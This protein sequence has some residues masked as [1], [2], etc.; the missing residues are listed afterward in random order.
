MNKYTALLFCAL[1][2]LS[3]CRYG[4]GKHV[5]GNGHKS[6]ETRNISGFTGVETHGDI[7]IIATVG[8]YSVKVEAEQNLLSY[9]E[10]VVEDGRL[11]VRI[12]DGIALYDFD[13]ATV[14]V[15]APMLNAFETHGSGNINGEQTFTAKDKI[16]VGVYGSGDVVLALDCPEVIAETHGSGNI[17][18]S[19]QTKDV[20][21]SISG[22]GDIKAANLKAE[23][24]K[25]TVHGSGNTEVFAS[26]TLNV[27]VF[28]S[29][30]VHY[31][32]EPKIS[33]VVHGSGAVS[34]M[35]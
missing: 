8:N 16:N 6:S 4:H 22:S 18:L 9:I 25:A 2:V 21:S 3:A 14:Y 35:N 13:G 10:T 29:G 20:N 23:N 5:S 1:S 27:E 26:E 31:Q 33:S 17:K 19:G 11:K 32:G 15:A 28:G 34:K 30:D 24:V 12:K 7:N